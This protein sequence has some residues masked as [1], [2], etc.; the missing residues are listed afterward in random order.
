M[1]DC[2]SC[3]HLRAERD[4]AQRERGDLKAAYLTVQAQLTSCELDVQRLQ[5]ALRGEEWQKLQKL[6]NSKNDASPQLFYAFVAFKNATD[7]PGET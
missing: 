5:E 1:T 7:P 6:A 3:E 4:A 2:E